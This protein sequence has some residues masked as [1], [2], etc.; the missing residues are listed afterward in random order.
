LII[1]YALCSYQAEAAGKPGYCPECGKS[2]L[3]KK[4]ARKKE[5][6]TM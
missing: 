6:C 4:L 2:S 3:R 1:L 5:I